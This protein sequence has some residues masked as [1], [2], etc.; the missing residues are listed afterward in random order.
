MGCSCCI[1][2]LRI[3]IQGLTQVHQVESSFLRLRASTAPSALFLRQTRALHATRNLRSEATASAAPVT[4]PK[5]IEASTTSQS[6]D[7]TPPVRAVRPR[8]DTRGQ[9]QQ[10]PFG[11]KPSLSVARTS[12]WK[13]ASD[14]KSN[15]RQPRKQWESTRQPNWRKPSSDAPEEKPK[16]P[17]W[18]AQKEA[19]KE[20][21]PEGWAPRKRLSPDALAG[22][23]AL[24]AQFPDI[25]TTDALAKKFEVSP[26]NIRRIL[27]SK[28]QP[29][30]DE[31]QSRQERWFRRGMS[32]W[33]RKAALGVKPPRK[34]R[35]EGI[36]RDPTYHAW[37]QEAT[38]K[39]KEFEDKENEI[40]REALRK[41]RPTGGS[42]GGSV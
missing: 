25:Y 19:L 10:K 20:K 1:T 12:R 37:R 3:F 5:P 9:S 13:S 17:H 14:T 41:R 34:W 23:R 15:D 31:E 4:P 40:H 36:A 2:P 18:A 6:K 24:N 30:V 11:T 32:V 38:R 27:K 33:E 8:K 29:S 7:D 26:E 39:N 16:T 21:F 28:W 42:E 35:Q 22:I